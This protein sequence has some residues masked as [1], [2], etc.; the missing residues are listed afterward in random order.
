MK[1]TYKIAVFIVLL[2]LLTYMYKYKFSSGEQTPKSSDILLVGTNAEFAPYSFIDNGNIVG[3][4]ID[5]AH[6][7]AKRLG[8]TITFKD[9]P[10]ESLLPELQLGRIEIIAAGI[11][12][13]Q[14]RAQK[15]LFTKPYVEGDKLVVLTRR[16]TPLI[17]S[18]DDLNGKKVVVND[19]FTAD[20][21]MSA[22][23]GS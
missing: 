10:F 7:V 21:Y 15:V 17:T 8:K 2:A 9:M 11:T 19:G 6:E 13:T 23:A 22:I 16:N 20:L 18:I 1:T 5:I 3:F 12:P 14:E 4:D